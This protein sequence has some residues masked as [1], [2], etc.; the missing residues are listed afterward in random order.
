VSKID[1]DNEEFVFISSRYGT[2]PYSLL[3]ALEQHSILC[4]SAKILNDL[5]KEIIEK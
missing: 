1:E 4:T 3:V 5:Y 2:R